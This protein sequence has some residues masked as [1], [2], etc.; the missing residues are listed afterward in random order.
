MTKSNKIIE[1][2]YP[3]YQAQ[4]DEYKKL[5]YDLLTTIVYANVS[6][7]ID[8]SLIIPSSYSPGPLIEYSHNIGAKVVLMFNSKSMEAG[9]NVLADPTIRTIAINNLINEIQKYN[10]DGIV[11]NI[12][13]LT[14]GINPNNG[15]SNKQ[16]MTDFITIL[17]DTIWNINPDYYIS[18]S[19]GPYYP[20]E[21]KVFDLAVIQNKLNYVKMRGYDWYGPWLPNVGPSSPIR[22]DSGT[23]IY[24]SLK[25]YL[26]SMDKNKLLL[27][28]PWYGYVFD[29]TDS[30][31]RS[32][33]PANGD[34]S[35]IGYEDYIVNINDYGRIWDS[36]WQ[37]PWVAF[38]E[39]HLLDNPGFELGMWKWGT[40]SNGTTHVFAYHE[41]G[42]LE[43]S[44][45]ST[46]YSIPE[47][48][49]SAAWIQTVPIDPMQTYIIKAYMKLDN[50]VGTGALIVLDWK[51]NDGSSISSNQVAKEVGSIDWTKYEYE[52]TPPNEAVKVTILLQLMNASG[53]V[54][55]DDIYFDTIIPTS[56]L[57][58]HQIQYDDLES[59]SIK[60]DL[61][62]SEG[63]AGIG[64]WTAP[65]GTDR[66]ELWKLIEDKF[67]F[68]LGESIVDEVTVSGFEGIPPTGEVIFEVSIDGKI[69]SQYGTNKKLDGNG[70]SISDP[71][72]P[73]TVDIYYFR[74]KF[75][76]DTNYNESTSGDNDESLIVNKINPTIT[77]FL[78]KQI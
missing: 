74:A 44:S 23:G 26:E 54:W 63:L 14:K 40:Y 34:V 7:Y 35:Y 29:S 37:T 25:H 61:V 69:W 59:L 43:G 20:D 31:R 60:Y 47:D 24:D 71:Y 55:F 39:S 32:P 53:K 11:I 45:V 76:G 18:L 12:E 62:N 9:D 73:Q 52:A 38:S 10:F 13:R 64:I 66:P 5:R 48:G 17:S 27:G 8:G 49:K 67:V 65:Y 19:I 78:K 22:L 42:R 68:I 75:L 46:E 72:T 50:V 6:I 57:R 56:E 4:S 30:T 36:V 3:C 28:V 21:D 70:K 58:W 16:L 77:T 2:A 15:I 1:V 51:R 33:R 41:P